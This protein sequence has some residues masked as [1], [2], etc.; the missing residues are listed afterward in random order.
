MYSRQI[1]YMAYIPHFH[2]ERDGTHLHFHR[3]SVHLD[4]EFQIIK[5]FK[6]KEIPSIW[7]SINCLMRNS[8]SEFDMP[9]ILASFI[10]LDPC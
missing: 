8:L 1:G 3:T 5:L 10:K 2:W 4:L 7:N 6:I 9:V